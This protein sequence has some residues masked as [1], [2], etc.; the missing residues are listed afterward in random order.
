MMELRLQYN[1][2]M[3]PDV[4]TRGSGGDS[5]VETGRLSYADRIGASLWGT[6]SEDSPLRADLLEREACLAAPVAKRTE[7]PPGLTA[8]MNRE[9]FLNDAYVRDTG[10]EFV[11]GATATGF[12]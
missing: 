10:F 7:A 3:G 2:E 1:S 12:Y 6:S 4:V 5:D 8:R 9:A 11:W